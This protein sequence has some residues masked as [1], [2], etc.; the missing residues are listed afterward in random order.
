MAA[1]TGGTIAACKI[2]RIFARRASGTDFI[3]T[4]HQ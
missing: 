3:S 2:L 4:R 1:R